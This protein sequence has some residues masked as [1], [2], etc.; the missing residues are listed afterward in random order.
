MAPKFGSPRAVLDGEK[1]Y[2]LTAALPV[3]HAM[4]RWERDA[5]AQAE[6]LRQ[7]KLWSAALVVA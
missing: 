7:T 1:S 5:S 4:S 6:A 2:K 3:P